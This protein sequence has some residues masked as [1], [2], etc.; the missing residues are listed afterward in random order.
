MG[1]Y[2]GKYWE[3]LNKYYV[4][5]AHCRLLPLPFQ[6]L[7]RLSHAARRARSRRVVPVVL[8][9]GFSSSLL[10]EPVLDALLFGPM[11]GN[12]KCRR[13][14]A[15]APAH[16]RDSNSCRRSHGRTLHAARLPERTQLLQV[17]RAGDVLLVRPA[18]AHTAVQV[19]VPLLCGA[20]ASPISHFA[21]F[22]AVF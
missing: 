5:G 22:K 8:G 17:L 15:R 2:Y 9:L 14:G 4:V 3:I 10:I 18:A 1:G 12:S 11:Q 19:V 13:T 6:N 21:D 20:S 7:R 16:L